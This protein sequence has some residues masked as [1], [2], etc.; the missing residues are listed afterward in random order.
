[1]LP[2]HAHVSRTLATLAKVYDGVLWGL[3]RINLNLIE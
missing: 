3:M 2:L 1:M